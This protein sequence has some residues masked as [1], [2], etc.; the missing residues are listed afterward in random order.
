LRQLLVSLVGDRIAH[1]HL[2]DDVGRQEW[3]LKA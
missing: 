2:H 1:I 3:V